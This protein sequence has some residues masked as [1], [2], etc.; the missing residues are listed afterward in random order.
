MFGKQKI[1]SAPKQPVKMML[2][3]G[4]VV[5]ALFASAGVFYYY[6]IFVPKLEQQKLDLEQQKIKQKQ[7]E[8]KALKKK[9][10]QA[11]QRKQVY[12]N[13]L[14]DAE[15]SYNNRWAN[16]CQQIVEQN[17]NNLEQ[18]LN[19]RRVMLNP[20]KGEAYC[21]ELFGKTEFN[22]NC[23]L[24]VDVADQLERNRVQA[25]QTC[26]SEAQHMVFQ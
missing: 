19:D 26:A 20:F 1:Q 13:C 11:E 8:Q 10:W 21:L 24:P 3:I 17:Q 4:L 22:A 2:A 18:C 9:Q 14:N 7:E 16:T 12:Q 6:V 15:Q 25:K 5:A 23:E